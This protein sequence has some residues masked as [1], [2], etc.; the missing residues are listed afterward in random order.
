M[1]FATSTPPKTAL[2]PASAQASAKMRR[3]LMPCASAA[4][5][6]SATARIAMPCRER[7]K[8]RVKPTSATAA[9][10][11]AHNLFTGTVA[12]R[13]STVPLGMKSGNARGRVPQMIW[14]IAPRTAASPIVTMIT[15]MTG[16]PT[17]GRRMSRSMTTPSAM[18]TATA[19]PTPTYHGDPTSTMTTRPRRRR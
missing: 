5:W 11:I 13:M 8:N 19:T 17:I 2:T 3:T 1:R 14:T 4:C 12:P 18:P 6:S 7:A 16:S 15:E 10:A 9:I